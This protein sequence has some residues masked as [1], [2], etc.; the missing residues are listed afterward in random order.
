MQKN[1]LVVVDDKITNLMLPYKRFYWISVY[2]ISAMYVTYFVTVDLGMTP[3]LQLYYVV[4]GKVIKV[5]RLDK[6]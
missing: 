1:A 5:E 2:K 6:S 4:D 3:K